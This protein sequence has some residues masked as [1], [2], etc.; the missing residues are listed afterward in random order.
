MAKKNKLEQLHQT[1]GK[2]E[3]F[4]PTTLDQIWGDNGMSAYG[5]NLESEYVEEISEMNK[6]DLY[7]HAVA[8][9]VVPCDD[10][11]MLTRKLIKQFND[12]WNAFKVP[13]LQVNPAK[14]PSKEIQKILAEGR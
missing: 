4:Q 1:H 7:R 14:M 9:G 13:K 3:T 11:N 5:T 6:T 2:V 12:H 8:K 10:R